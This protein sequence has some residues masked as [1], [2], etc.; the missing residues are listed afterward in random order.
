MGS[1]SNTEKVSHLSMRSLF[2]AWLLIPLM[3]WTTVNAYVHV[4]VFEMC[5]YNC[6]FGFLLGEKTLLASAS[7]D[8]ARFGNCTVP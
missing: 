4:S 2:D 1:A 5:V 7:L 8:E 3:L 6:V